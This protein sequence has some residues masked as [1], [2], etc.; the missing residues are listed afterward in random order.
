MLSKLGTLEKN[1]IASAMEVPN[2]YIKILEMVKQDNFDAYEVWHEVCDSI[3]I[4]KFNSFSAR[5]ASV[6]MQNKFA[7]NNRFFDELS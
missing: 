5:L 3:C 7:L 2:G 6:Q 1:Y 4:T